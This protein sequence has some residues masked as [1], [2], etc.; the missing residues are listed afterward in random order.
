[1]DKIKI[2]KFGLQESSPEYEQSN[3]FLNIAGTRQRL[4]SRSE[5][6]V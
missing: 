4:L 1:M 2:S 6:S 3:K 5:S